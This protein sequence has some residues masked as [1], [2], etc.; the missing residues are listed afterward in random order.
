VH[1]APE[2]LV[3]SPLFASLTDEQLRAVASLMDIVTQ[4]AGTTLVGE[5][6]PGFSVFVLLDGT[7]DATA[8]DLPLSTLRAGDYFGEIALLNAA[9]RTAT[10]TA[11]SPVTLAVMYGSDFRVFE[12]DFPSTAEQMK[13]T[14]ARRLERSGSP[15]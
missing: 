12:R 6:A 9:R 14:T 11:T 3:G 7:A 8:E 2:Q 4:P 1:P 13:E 15:E 5:G 10:V